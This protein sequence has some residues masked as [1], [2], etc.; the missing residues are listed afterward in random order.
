MS[1]VIGPQREI[2]WRQARA[3]EAPPARPESSAEAR[4]RL[5]S[6]NADF[7]RLGD[8][9]GQQ[10]SSVGPE[11]FGLPAVDGD[12]V[13][14]EPFAA[15]LAC[16]DARAPVEMLFNQAGNSIFVVRTAGFVL[17][18][19]S[20]GS[21][22]YAVG[23]LPTVKMVTVLGH[24]DC[25]AM[26]AAADALLSPQAYLDILHDPSLRAIVDAL[27]AGVRMADVA[28]VDAYGRDVRDSPRF[29]SALIDLAATANAA[30]TAVVLNRT[31]GC[32]VS[33]G[34]FNL[35]NR[36]VGVGGPDGWR[37]G[38]LDPPADERELGALL[39]RGA[40][41]AAL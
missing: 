8:R 28:L 41:A 1:G 9:G 38:L 20:L 26:T 19:E 11:A 18:R 7:A 15:V 31:V 6:G 16:S 14:Q 21:L 2:I 24:T 17:G 32:P 12:G 27:L 30:I 40:D 33:F 29:R 23:N 35:N 22:N 10:I 5:E 34:V 13:P 4:A 39:S 3:D 36:T 37:A 25:G